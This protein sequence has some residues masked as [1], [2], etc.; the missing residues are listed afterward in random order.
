MYLKGGSSAGWPLSGLESKA[1]GESPWVDM[2]IGVVSFKPCFFG[3]S[4]ASEGL[5]ATSTTSGDVS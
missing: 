2:S 4:G 1:F 5:T 3:H